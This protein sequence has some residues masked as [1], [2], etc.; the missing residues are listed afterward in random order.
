MT[1]HIFHNALKTPRNEQET[2]CTATLQITELIS[3][4]KSKITT[5]FNGSAHR[6]FSRRKRP[7]SIYDLL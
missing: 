3:A 4:T 5:I 1:A 7:R 2:Y 6:R